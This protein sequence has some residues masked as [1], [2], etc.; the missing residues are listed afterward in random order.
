LGEHTLVVDLVRTALTSYPLRERLTS[1]LML[2]L[3][4]SGRQAEALQAYSDL[5]RRLDAEL[6]VAPAPELR[7]LEEDV[8]LQRP[9]L[10]VRAARTAPVVRTRTPV[11]RF[12][13]RR[14]EV[15]K[16]L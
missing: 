8:L 9:S 15:S 2:A 6:G 14:A 10:D 16:L 4:R 7:R 12:V 5:A 11:G 13:G 1:S 3:Y